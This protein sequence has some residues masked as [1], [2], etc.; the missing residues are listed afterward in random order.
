[1]AIAL[2]GAAMG[3]PFDF[4]RAPGVLLAIAFFGAACGVPPDDAVSGFGRSGNGAGLGGAVSGAG[5]GGAAGGPGGAG[6]GGAGGPSGGAGSGGGGGAGGPSGGAGS[7]N[8]AGGPSGGTGSGGAAAVAGAAGGEQG[9]TAGA[10]GQAGASGAGGASGASGAP[11]PAGDV[12]RGAVVYQGTCGR[13]MC[14]GPERMGPDLAILVRLYDA[15]RI[16]ST[17]RNGVRGLGS[18]PGM[19]A[20]RQL[21]DQDI[22]DVLAYLRATYPASP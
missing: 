12:A 15:A 13:A 17:I 19:P 1:M 2:A 21:T 22:A 10:G 7:G 4:I 9:G 8:G 11:L 14:H 3:T 5:S 20:Q 6:S 18:S 16:V